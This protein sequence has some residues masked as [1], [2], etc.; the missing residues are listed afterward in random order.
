MIS[1][2]MIYGFNLIIENVSQDLIGIMSF[3]TSIV[4]IPFLI[5]G[6]K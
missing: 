2:Y 5:L 3:I 1:N 6:Y 4:S